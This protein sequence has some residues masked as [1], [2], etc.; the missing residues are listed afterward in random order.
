MGQVL[1]FAE[2]KTKRVASQRVSPRR[3]GEQTYFC[4]GCDADRFLLYPEGRVQCAHCGA[5]MENLRVSDE[6]PP[7]AS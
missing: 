3:L 1:R 6:S 2:R 7:T 5:L 4:M